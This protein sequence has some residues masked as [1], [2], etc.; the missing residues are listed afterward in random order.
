MTSLEFSREKCK[1]YSLK[2]LKFAVPLDNYEVSYLF[3]VDRY[4][5]TGKIRGTEHHYKIHIDNNYK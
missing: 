1:S 4:E 5:E 2:K 3:V